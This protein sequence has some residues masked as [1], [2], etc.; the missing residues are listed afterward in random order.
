MRAARLHAGGGQLRR[1][2]DVDL[3]MD[4]AKTKRDGGSSNYV[5]KPQLS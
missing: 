4:N 1:L 2:E 5:V 3:A